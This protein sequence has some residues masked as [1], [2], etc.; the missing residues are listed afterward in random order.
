MLHIGDDA[1]LDVV[2]ALRAGLQVAWIN[3]TGLTWDHAPLQPHTT[4][5]DLMDLCRQIG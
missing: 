1:V 4:V 3:R 2:G 5:A